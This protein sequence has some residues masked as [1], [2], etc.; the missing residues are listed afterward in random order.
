M[1]RCSI[2][3]ALCFQFATLDGKILNKCDASCLHYVCSPTT[4]KWTQITAFIPTELVSIYRM[5]I[6]QTSKMKPKKWEHDIFFLRKFLSCVVFSTQKYS[7]KRML[8]CDDSEMVISL[9]FT[10][11]SYS[12]R[13][14]ASFHYI[15]ISCPSNREKQKT[16]AKLLL[17][18]NMNR[19]YSTEWLYLISCAVSMFQLY[20][21]S[22]RLFCI[23]FAWG[24]GARMPLTLD[25]QGSQS[26][27]V[28]IVC[29]HSNWVVSD[30]RCSSD[31]KW[32]FCEFF[33]RRATKRHETPTKMLAKRKKNMFM[34]SR[35]CSDPGDSQ[36]VS[37]EIKL[38]VRRGLARL[39][40]D[41]PG[42]AGTAQIAS[43]LSDLAIDDLTS[44]DIAKDFRSHY[45]THE[46]RMR[47]IIYTKKL[48]KAI[49]GNAH[50]FK[51]K[52]WVV[53]RVFDSNQLKNKTN[54]FCVFL[55]IELSP[56]DFL[57]I[58]NPDCAWCEL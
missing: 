21:F 39:K 56:C 58:S 35:G 10:F 26:D 54:S 55:H 34:S 9:V 25:S 43:Q 37:D 30:F 22:G 57:S 14:N 4:Q 27:W 42:E 16:R 53:F 51:D 45:R 7:F 20:L 50:L 48:W 38:N 19:A 17:C 33:F 40:S 12:N 46:R 29:L 3:F 41:K 32:L 6:K 8:R 44:I 15:F 2:L 13:I 24:A 36:C 49:C 28:G 47:D 18:M 52:V 11:V 5:H 31:K 1:R 23:P